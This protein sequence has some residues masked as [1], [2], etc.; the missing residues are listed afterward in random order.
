M[1]ISCGPPRFF[2]VLASTLTLAAACSTSGTTGTTGT[3]QR[4][5]DGGSTT[6][7]VG[8]S[9]GYE[10]AA[11]PDC[12]GGLTCFTNVPGGYC[13]TNCSTDADC[14]AGGNCVEPLP[15]EQICVSSCHLV[16]DCV[17]A[18]YGCDTD[19]SVCVPNGTQTLVSCAGHEAGGGGRLPDGGVCG[20][21]LG[22]G[23]FASWSA[24]VEVS[25]NPLTGSEAQ[26]ALLVGGSASLTT[27]F[28]VVPGDAGSPPP[29]NWIGLAMSLDDGAGFTSQAPIAEEPGTIVGDPSLGADSSGNLYLAYFGYDP[30]RGGIGHLWVSAAQAGG[31]WGSPQDV[32]G[33]ADLADAG[34]GVDWPFLAVNPVTQQPLIVFSDF[35]GEFGGFGP[36]RIKLIAGQPGGTSFLPSVDVD[37]GTRLAFRDLPSMAFDQTGMLYLTWVEAS[38]PTTVAEDQ[39]TGVELTGSTTNAIYFTTA[40]GKDGGAVTV[41]PSNHLVAGADAGGSI[42]VDS[43]HLAVAPDGTEVFVTYVVAAAGGGTDI[44]L[45]VSHNQGFTWPIHT[46]VD[47]QPGCATHFHPAP[48]LDIKNRLW[49]SW[50]DNRDGFGNVYCA[51]SYNSGVSFSASQLVSS[52]PFFFT[53][54]IP[55]SYGSV[56]AWQGGSQVLSGSDTELYSMWTGAV[57]GTT[58]NS[59]AHVYFAK[60]P[61]P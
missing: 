27:A 50:V 17:R 57:G 49:V 54:L 23:G 2:C 51:I 43:A 28:M 1:Q 39:A 58:N 32:L 36:Y 55:S 47:D 56:P 48:F 4:R 40:S 26:G 31:S 46:V 25:A 60:A 29:Q 8:S 10:C 13:S 6:G 5:P 18:G 12:G 34:G 45:A 33:A 38:D 24:A 53:T 44:A 41:A 14:P 42:V 35:A 61:L 7:S 21:S 19:C 3:I 22:D 20:A 59:A 15:G 9:L 52:E 37:D 30:S 16:N 11:D